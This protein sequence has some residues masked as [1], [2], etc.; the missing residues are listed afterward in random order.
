M[1]RPRSKMK[2]EA[3][4][5]ADIITNADFDAASANVD[6]TDEKADNEPQSSLPSIG[7]AVAETETSHESQSPSEVYVRLHISHK[8][9]M[10]SDHFIFRILRYALSTEMITESNNGTGN[11]SFENTLEPQAF[12]VSPTLPMAQWPRY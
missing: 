2:Q 6:V 7:F 11:R 8:H 4:E 1:S 10:P 3:G 9:L 5:D 12:M